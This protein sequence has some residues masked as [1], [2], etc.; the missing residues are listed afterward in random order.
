MFVT[1]EAGRGKTTLLDAFLS[2]ARSD[3]TVQVATGQCIQ[4]Q[5]Q[6]EPYL[7]ILDMLG[8]LGRAPDG[9]ALV[10]LLT[11]RAP[12]W[13]AQLPWLVPADA[14]AAVGQWAQAA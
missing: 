7:P 13:L 6:D 12:T 14:R 11:E 9:P 4:Y 5:G 10:G 1:G 2:V 8:R 3:A